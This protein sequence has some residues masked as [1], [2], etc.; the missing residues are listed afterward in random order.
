LPAHDD[1]IESF[2]ASL[3]GVKR[4]VIELD[5]LTRPLVAGVAIYADRSLADADWAIFA[6]KWLRN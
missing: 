4:G 6:D 1:A 2:S 5:E 3:D